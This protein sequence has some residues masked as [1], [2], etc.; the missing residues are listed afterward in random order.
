MP[1]SLGWIFLAMAGGIVVI[2]CL[3][4]AIR[5][6]A[7]RPEPFGKVLFRQRDEDDWE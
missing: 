7:T 5:R 3:S 1:H 4:I 6:E 2:V